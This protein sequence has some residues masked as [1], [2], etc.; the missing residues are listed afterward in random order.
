LGEKENNA[1]RKKEPT[2]PATVTTKNHGLFPGERIKMTY[3]G[4]YHPAETNP[5]SAQEN[6]NSNRSIGIKKRREEE[7]IGNIKHSLDPKVGE[8][9]KQYN[10]PGTREVKRKRGGELLEEGSGKGKRVGWLRLL[11]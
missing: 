1:L 2:G 3:G 4:R 5:G 11:R 9:K 10:T 7:G 6:K 8:K